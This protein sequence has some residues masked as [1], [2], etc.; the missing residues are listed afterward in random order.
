MSRKLVEAERDTRIEQ[1]GG[2]QKKAEGKSNT[3][4]VLVLSHSKGLINGVK[5]ERIPK[6]EVAAASMVSDKRE[7][8]SG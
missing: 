7:S 6:V 8:L 1:I 2:E 5:H 3:P 4:V